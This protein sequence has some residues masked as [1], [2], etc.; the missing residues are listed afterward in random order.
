MCAT[1]GYCWR[2]SRC[3][4]LKCKRIALK[5]MAHRAA[6]SCPSESILVCGNG[7]LTQIGKSPSKAQSRESGWAPAGSRQQAGRQQPAA[8]KP[9][10]AMERSDRA[11][12][13]S[14]ALRIRCTHAFGRAGLEK[15]SSQQLA[16][17]KPQPAVEHSDRANAF[18]RA[19]RIGSVSSLRQI[20][21]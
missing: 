5:K 7:P 20:R 9:Q 1:C 17:N 13:F 19:L 15:A 14:R 18:S 10:A 12:A 3:E 21:H 11:N 8:R 16:A 6:H 4:A 2:I